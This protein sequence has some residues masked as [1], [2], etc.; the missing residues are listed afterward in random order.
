[1]KVAVLFSG[2]KDSVRTVH[3]CLKKGYDV[4]YLVTMIPEREDSWLFHT[5]NIDFAELS[6]EA[7]GTLIITKV[8]SGVKEKEL[9][10]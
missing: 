9:K 2:G 6:A 3:W 10:R 4:K 1:M 5:P 8:T 7:I